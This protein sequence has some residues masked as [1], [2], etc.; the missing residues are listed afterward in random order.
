[1]QAVLI[2]LFDRKDGTGA[3]WVLMLDSFFQAAF[4]IADERLS[5]D[6][7]RRLMR[8]VYTGAYDRAAGNS[9]G[10][11]AET[12]NGGQGKTGAASSNTAKGHKPRPR[13]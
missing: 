8:R 1:M 2:D 9:P 10:G 3:D 11:K 5:D 12:E 7:R 4:A 6:T 13:R